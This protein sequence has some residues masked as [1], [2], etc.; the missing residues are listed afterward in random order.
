[1]SETFFGDVAGPIPFAGLGSS[2]ALAYKVY[3]PDRLVLG[4]RMAD[5][6]RISVCL[7]HSFAWP[8]SD[9][10]GSGTFDRPWNDAGLEPLEAAR[11]KLD[12]AFEF[13]VKLGVPFFAFHDRD[14]APEGGSYRET[15]RHPGRGRRA[16]RGPHGADGVQP[17]VGHGQPVHPPAVRRRRGDQSRSGG[18]RLGGG[19]GQ[20]DA[21]GD[22]PARWRELRP[23]GRPRG[24][25]DAA[26]HGPGPRGAP[27]R[28]LPA[29]RRGA[30]AQDRVRGH[31]PA[32]AEA[33]GTD[34]APV[35][36]RQRHGPR[37]PRPA[38]AGRTSTGSTSRP[39]T[40]PS[41]ATRSTTRS[42]TRR[43][44]GSSAASTR[45]GA[46]TRTAG[47]R[48]SSRTR[49]RSWPWR[50]TRSSAAGGFTTGGFNFDAK[51][52]RQ[53]LDRNDLF[54]GHIGGIDTL[55]RA[56][57]VAA[58]LIESG[59]LERRREARYAGWA[60][61]LGSE[62]LGEHLSLEALEARVAE[63]GIDP[64][65][66]SGRQEALENLV[67]QRIWAADR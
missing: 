2:D 39:T 21:R 56:L 50:C 59:E 19:A 63:G 36:L 51:L 4:K 25:R 14:V 41:P 62:I 32:R 13:L 55:A 24:L 16:H 15:T 37:L 33:P 23:V 44:T 42:R 48:T 53:S 28:P 66:V 60:G 45:T 67:N 43:P 8:G 61:G 22:P 46:T 29:P 64:K 52:R 1:M 54:H 30:Q 34:Q 10:F 5:H 6:L 49:W 12:A 38:R 7:W 35:R 9:V 58:D 31:A 57:L 27:A 40:R 18:L 17:A 20:D 65:P 11:M 3:E 47:T 26:Q